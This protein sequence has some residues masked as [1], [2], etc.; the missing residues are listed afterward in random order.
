[1][2]TVLG[3]TTADSKVSKNDSMGEKNSLNTISKVGSFYPFS[4]L[5][6]PFF[7]MANQT[8]L[9]RLSRPS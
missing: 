5:F 2:P 8:P 9:T 7:S 1:M 3:L 4:L 6:S